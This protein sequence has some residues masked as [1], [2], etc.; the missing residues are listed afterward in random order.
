MAGRISRAVRLAPLGLPLLT[1]PALSPLL[2]RGPSCVI[3]L[4]VDAPDT[5]SVDEPPF[6]P[7]HVQAREVG[8]ERVERPCYIA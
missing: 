3:S 4:R 2:C 1:R 5:L 7:T 8:W 6:P